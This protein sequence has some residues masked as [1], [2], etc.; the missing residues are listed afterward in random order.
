MN[1][2]ATLVAEARNGSSEAFRE[3]VLRN[4]NHVFAILH[5]YERDRHLLED[6]AQDSF[7][8]A[9]RAL[10]S[11]DGRAPFQ[12]WLSRI[13]VNVAID[14]VRR[15]KRLSGGVSFSDLGKD[16]H[17]WL[18]D[19]FPAR[20][21]Q[22]RQAREILDIAMNALSPAERVVITL[23]ELEDRSVM[24]VSSLTGYSNIAVRVRAVR[25]R[26]KLRKAIERL[27]KAEP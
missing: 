12:H 8:K 6:L 19:G 25:A 9:W 17:E 3:L 21:Q 5:R 18:H 20:E 27:Q 24:E 1:D 7:T 15:R 23:L 16:A 22:A 13:A 26:A 10:A 2:D 14:H 11:Y 4:Q